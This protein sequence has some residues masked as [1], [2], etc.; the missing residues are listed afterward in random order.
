MARIDHT[1]AGARTQAEEENKKR[2]SEIKRKARM[3]RS[4][5]KPTTNY[6]FCF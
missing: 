1:A 5:G 2:Q 4:R 6:C 3:M